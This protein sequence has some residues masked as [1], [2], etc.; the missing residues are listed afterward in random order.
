ME[1]ERCA[2]RK[3]ACGNRAGGARAVSELTLPNERS[4]VR[5]AR[6]AGA[7]PGLRVADVV[8][9]AVPPWRGRQD[10]TIWVRSSEM[11]GTQEGADA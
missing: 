10:M 11:A 8:R 5:P 7:C 9:E 4:R 6:L 2:G 3:A 1:C